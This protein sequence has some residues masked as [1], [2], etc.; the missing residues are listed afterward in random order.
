MNDR[1]DSF[2]FPFLGF[3]FIFSLFHIVHILSRY[4]IHTG[5][6]S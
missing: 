1:G 4:G 6:G 3:D 5:S 2:F